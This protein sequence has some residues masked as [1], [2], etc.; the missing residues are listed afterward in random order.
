MALYP[1]WYA[2]ALDQNLAMKDVRATAQDQGEETIT[3]PAGTF[4]CRKTSYD[5]NLPGTPPIIPPSE[6]HTI[7]WENGTVGLVKAHLG[8]KITVNG[9]TTTADTTFELEQKP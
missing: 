1:D 5:K 9:G 2:N 3:V 4:V 6:V 7:L 8:G